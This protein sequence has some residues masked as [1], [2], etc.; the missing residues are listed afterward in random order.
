MQ[1]ENITNF[2]QYSLKP[3]NLHSNIQTAT[4]FLILTKVFCYRF[5]ILKH[6]CGLNSLQFNNTCKNNPNHTEKV[7]HVQRINVLLTP[8]VVSSSLILLAVEPQVTLGV[9]LLYIPCI[10]L[11]ANFS[12]Q[13]RRHRRSVLPPGFSLLH[14]PATMKNL[15]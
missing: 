4:T 11:M 10:S 9:T 14:Y 12:W 13:P 8:F 1:F 6:Q 5:E 3:F 7:T 15:P 2:L